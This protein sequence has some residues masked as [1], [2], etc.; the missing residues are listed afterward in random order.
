MTKS[1]NE[2]F[3]ERADVHPGICNDDQPYPY[4]VYVD[5][6]DVMSE[7]NFGAGKLLRFAPTAAQFNRIVGK[8]GDVWAQ[9]LPGRRPGE[10]QR[11]DLDT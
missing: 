3:H 11:A 4:G 5:Q 10:V 6:H 2:P 9:E 1:P 7:S 8:Q